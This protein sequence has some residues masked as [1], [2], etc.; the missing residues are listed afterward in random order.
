[1]DG[2]PS[3][4]L[5]FARWPRDDDSGRKLRAPDSINNNDAPARA[6]R[7]IRSTGSPGSAGAAGGRR[8]LGRFRPWSRP[9]SCG[10][11]GGGVA[12]VTKKKKTRAWFRGGGGVSFGQGARA[13]APARSLSLAAS[14]GVTGSSA[15]V[16][17]A[18]HRFLVGGGGAPSGRG[19][20]A[21]ARRGQEKL[22]GLSG[23]RAAFLHND[24]LVRLEQ[25]V[26][27]ARAA[28][29]A[30]VLQGAADLVLGHFCFA[31]AEG[32][33]VGLSLFRVARTRKEQKKGRRS[34]EL[35]PT[36][37]LCV[38]YACAGQLYVGGST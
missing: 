30:L 26:H 25:P 4:G 35:A 29:V 28:A 18:P 23:R 27:W 21:R 7:C 19:G 2:T 6:S 3:R 36:T 16:T 37:G 1:M 14:L 13:P 32:Q 33:Q 17:A 31:R 12:P 38:V 24:S 20:G 11:W 9:I 8:I 22:Q 15:E 10:S 5:F 34:R